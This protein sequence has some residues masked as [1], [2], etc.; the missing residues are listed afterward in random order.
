[1]Q[2]TQLQTLNA[3]QE[4][5][6][7]G[8][9]EF[10]FS[11]KKEINISGPG[12]YG[13]TFL[14]GHMIDTI[15]PR[16]FDTCKMMGLNPIYNSVVMTATTNKAAQVLSKATGQAAQT[17][18]SFLALKVFDDYTTGKTRIT[19]T[20]AWKVHEG[21]IIFVDEA[22]MMD[23][24]LHQFLME[25]TSK[26]KIVYV[27][28]QYQL[29]PISEETAPVYRMGL[30]IF[31]L[32]EPVRNAEQPALMTLCDQ[33]RET[34]KTG[35]FH[36]ISLVPGVIER[37]DEH[38]MP[39][40]IEEMLMDQNHENMILAYTN[41]RVI[42]YNDHIRGMRQQPE[43]YQVGDRLINNNPYKTAVRMI[44]VEEELTIW[45]Q[46]SHTTLVTIEP[47]VQMEVRDT[48]LLSSLGGVFTSTLP[49]NRDHFRA[50]IKYY[51]RKK[52]WATYFRLRGEF[53]DLR[54]R[55]ASTIHKSQGSTYDY[56][57]IDLGN[58][59]TCT[60]PKVIA[61]LL[62]V[63]VS[64]ARRGIYLFGELSE[65]YGGSAA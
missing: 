26:C 30:P 63:A 60:Q 50:L 27:G 62:Y 16:Y 4:A 37:L 56:A 25:G 3:G 41:D 45:S 35:V 48:T 47:G 7:E 5:A 40:K 61:R 21:L 14:L 65:K 32:T 12:G 34:A 57:F 23:Y 36:P 58:L 53:M 13:K 49:V 19:K 18:H 59:N 33:M 11:D 17:L 22:P 55:D 6:A 38:T 52:D 24:E 1:M 46:A 51:T 20:K 8:F 29:G 39:L 15:M 9:F 43:E 10:L 54:P 2:E 44:S 42:D 28:D 31:E 64:R